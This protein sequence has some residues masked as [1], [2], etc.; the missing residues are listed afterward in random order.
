M[1]PFM[2]ALEIDG[3]CCAGVHILLSAGGDEWGTW[4]AKDA[5]QSVPA[6]S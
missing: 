1:Y 3:V 6:R 2:C 5:A 4:L